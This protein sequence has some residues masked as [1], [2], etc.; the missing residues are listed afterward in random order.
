MVRKRSVRGAACLSAAAVLAVLLSPSRLLAVDAL[1]SPEAAGDA[2]IEAAQ[3]KSRERRRRSKAREPKAPERKSIESAKQSA[4]AKEERAVAPPKEKVRDAKAADPITPDQAKPDQAK[5]GALPAPAADPKA[6]IKD[7]WT[8]QEI[9]GALMACLKTLGPAVAEIEAAPPVRSG[10]CGAP[11]PVLLRRVGPAPGVEL[12]PPAMM[13]CEMVARLHDW[14]ETVVQPAAREV[15]GAPVTQLGNMSGYDCRFRNNAPFGK[16]SEHGLANALDIGGFVTANKRRVDVLTHWGPTV[17]DFEAEAARAAEREKEAKQG[18]SA[19]KDAES[20]S[21]GEPSRNAGNGESS[22]RLPSRDAAPVEQIAAQPKGKTKRERARRREEAAKAARADERKDAT[23]RG[24]AKRQ[25]GNAAAGR[26]EKEPSDS[27]SPRGGDRR[28]ALPLPQAP[29]A[30]VVAT[31]ERSFLT[32]IH[33]G[34]CGIFT[35]VLGPEAN[36]AHRN[37]FHVDLASRRRKS[38]CE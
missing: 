29:N 20:P 15:L 8:D 16:L 19:K 1:V 33:K 31:P 28:E 23:K 25:G 14:I 11:A 17:R 27:P 21:S 10:Q 34:A 18:P 36:E 22:S 6:E 30:V 9:I 26:A 12:R 37:H 7:A 2:R 4:P 32:R 5:P 3:R 38:F 35:T 24:G 13:N